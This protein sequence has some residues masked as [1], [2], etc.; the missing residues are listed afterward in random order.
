MEHSKASIT[1]SSVQWATDIAINYA[2][3]SIEGALGYLADKSKKER[4]EKGECKFCF[5]MRTQRIG[6]AAMTSQPCGICGEYQMYGSTNTDK[7]CLKCAKKHELCKY[8]GA[9]LELRPRRVFKP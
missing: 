3:D 2:Q 9:D 7:I 6:G 5:Y 8:C 4:R 1:A